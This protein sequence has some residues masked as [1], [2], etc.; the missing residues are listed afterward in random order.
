MPKSGH[1][2]PGGGALVLYIFLPWNHHQIWCICI[3]TKSYHGPLV[4]IRFTPGDQY[5][6]GDMVGSHHHYC[7]WSRC[8]RCSKHFLSA[9]DASLGRRVGWSRSIIDKWSCMSI[10]EWIVQPAP[11]T[12]GMVKLLRLSRISRQN[13]FRH[14]CCSFANQ[15]RFTLAQV[16]S[17]SAWVG[18][19][20]EGAFVSASSQI[21]CSWRARTQ[22]QGSC[23]QLITTAKYL[24]FGSATT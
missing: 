21:P 13:T 19:H 1:D 24:E 2:L 6:S 23:M 7:S 11:N 16:Y 12:E 14:P 18:H 8:S 10:L 4:L 9:N 5:G 3:K 22:P 15:W 20:S 17:L